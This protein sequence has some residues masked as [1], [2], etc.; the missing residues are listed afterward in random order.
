MLDVRHYP[1]TI[2]SGV[3]ATIMPPCNTRVWAV[4]SCTALT[5]GNQVLLTLGEYP[6]G[7]YAYDY[8]LNNVGDFFGFD[9]TCQWFG[10]VQA[11]CAG[12]GT[13]NLMVFEVY[14]K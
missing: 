12:G 14:N 4:I 8:R 1:I 11:E 10:S 5:A 13:T 9:P 6:A 7:G 2:T 3:G